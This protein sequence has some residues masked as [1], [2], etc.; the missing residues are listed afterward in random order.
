M[1]ILFDWNCDTGY[2]IKTMPFKTRR[3][4]FYSLIVVFILLGAYLL[5]N[6]Q[7][8]V[9]DLKNLRIVKTGALFLKYSPADATIEINGKVND[10]SPG[11]FST[12][13]FIS[14]LAPGEYDIKLS[15][16][17]YFP[18][19]KNL[20]VKESIVTAASQI[21]LWPDKFTLIP[22]ATSSIEDFRL[23]G[24]GMLIQMASG[25]INWGNAVLRGQGIVL[26]DP[27]SGL[28][29]TSDAKN[30]F[31]T[32]LNGAKAP[33][34]LTNLLNST[35]LRFFI[36]PFSGGKILIVT[37][38]ALYSFDSSRAVLEKLAS[39]TSTID[40]ASSNNEVFLENKNGDLAAFNLFLRTESSYGQKL[41]QNAAMRTTP[42]GSMIF[43]LED[44]GDLSVYDRSLDKIAVLEKN[45]ADFFVSPDEKKIAIAL[46][47][48][49]LSIAALDDYYGDI[50][51]KKG[52]KWAIHPVSGSVSDFA[53]LND[54]PNYGLILS[55]G[56]LFLTELD[57][58]TPQNT[59]PVTSGVKKFFVQGNNLYVL[60][61]DGTLSEIILK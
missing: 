59:Y 55:N 29:I 20:D 49:T 36:H 38:N 44:N 33:V 37:K 54:Y 4:F 12:G 9:L 3:L 40:A 39:A 10:T 42:S 21:K 34:N 50:Q 31:L 19:E 41:P 26:S 17:D 43:L 23:T 35:P 52:E 14:K 58:R 1:G 24:Q 32:D 15:R 2:I 22:V 6:A 61:S 30:Y 51:V 60:K 28:V 53:W 8:W 57:S 7:G 47:D 46:K 16:A 45:V 48:N 56:D 13:V 27:S 5:I 11:L 18:W 25:R